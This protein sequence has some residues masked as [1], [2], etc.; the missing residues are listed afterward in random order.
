MNE[1]EIAAGFAQSP[2]YRYAET[3]GHQ[4]FVAGQVPLDQEGQIVGV[5]D[6][7]AQ[8]RK[9]LD[10]LERLLELYEFERA[11]IRSLVIHVVG[12][13]QNLD[14]GWDAVLAWFHEDVP[15]AT[16]LGAA[17]LG[18]AGQVVEIQATVLR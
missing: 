11:N 3:V 12:E 7:G 1:D 16:L 9:C 15:P 8:A 13:Q 5:G 18:Y 2:G 6:P 10:N 4:L 17:R 14:Q